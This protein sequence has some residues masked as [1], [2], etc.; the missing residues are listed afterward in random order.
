MKLSTPLCDIAHVLTYSSGVLLLSWI[1]SDLKRELT[2]TTNILCEVIKIVISLNYAEV[3][4]RLS[5]CIPLS[6]VDT[7]THP[8]PNTA[9]G[10]DDLC[11]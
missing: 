5:N 2:I 1:V 8:C 10:S 11:Y 3:K 4:M 9:A 7:I 6:I